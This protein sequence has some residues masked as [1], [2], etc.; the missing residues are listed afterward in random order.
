L[1]ACTRKR[2]EQQSYYTSIEHLIRC[3]LFELLWGRSPKIA[4]V[5]QFLARAPRKVT[6]YQGK[7]NCKRDGKAEELEGNGL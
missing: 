1:C 4:W 2:D 6:T 3:A 7:S 5:T